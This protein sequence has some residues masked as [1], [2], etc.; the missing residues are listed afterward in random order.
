MTTKATAR[1]SVHVATSE[2]IY[3]GRTA[4]SIVRQMRDTQWNAPEQKRDW[5]IEVSER[6]FQSHGIVVP[7]GLS[8]DEFLDALHIAGVAKV[9]RIR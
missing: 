8:A 2:G 6:L 1:G 3:L 7:M 4:Q 9:T 5:M